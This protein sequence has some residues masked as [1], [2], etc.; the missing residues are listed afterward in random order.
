MV[1]LLLSADP[2]LIGNVDAVESAVTQTAVPLTTDQVCGSDTPETVPNNV[3]GWGLIDVEAA[4]PPLP[5]AG[6]MIYTPFG[7]LGV[8]A[9]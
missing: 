8:F 9:P 3:Y 2:D 1:A 6:Y 4:A 5:P 7:A